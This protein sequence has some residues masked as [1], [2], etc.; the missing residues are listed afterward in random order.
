[1]LFKFKNEGIKSHFY[2]RKI[3]HHKLLSQLHQM[4]NPI[5]NQ[6]HLL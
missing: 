1:M 5:K 4:V 3:M 6:L 2:I